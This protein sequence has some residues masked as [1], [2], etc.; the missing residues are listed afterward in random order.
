MYTPA[1]SPCIPGRSGSK[2]RHKVLRKKTTTVYVQ[3]T[4][5][6]QKWKE[7]QIAEQQHGIVGEY[8]NNTPYSLLQ[9]KKKDTEKK[10][11]PNALKMKKNN[12]KDTWKCRMGRTRDERL[13]TIIPPE[14]TTAQ[15]GRRRGERTSRTSK[16]PYWRGFRSFQDTKNKQKAGDPTIYKRCRGRKNRTKVTSDQHFVTHAVHDIPIT[17]DR[18][19]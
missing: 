2:V 11:N 8:Q 12:E 4:E 14:R 10:I 7:K 19:K 15:R 16:F 13:N 17:G 3:S 6:Q 18:S 9:E 5:Q 1:W